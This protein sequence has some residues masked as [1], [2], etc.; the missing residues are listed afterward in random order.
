[1]NTANTTPTLTTDGSDRSSA[2]TTTFSCE[3]LIIR[4]LRVTRINLIN[5]KADPPE[6][7]NISI[8]D[9]T[10][11]AKSNKFQVSRQYCQGPYASTFI[12]N[13]TT[14]NS[15]NETLRLC[16]V[17]LIDDAGSRSGLSSARTIPLITIA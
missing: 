10:T 12:T 11:Q 14:N 4:R 3:R 17:W 8:T 9:A 6:T 13:S 2:S 15:A 7:F 5:L 1:M 16:S